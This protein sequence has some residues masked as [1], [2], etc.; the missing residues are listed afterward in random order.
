[1]FAPPVS[2]AGCWGEGLGPRCPL[3][4]SAE[5][6]LPVPL[7]M[8]QGEL[9]QPSIPPSLSCARVRVAFCPACG[10]GCSPL[11]GDPNQSQTLALPYKSK[12]PRSGSRTHNST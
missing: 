2:W 11:V 10:K 5:P 9:L 6:H 4:A 12:Q 8:T 7:N 1:M 3:R